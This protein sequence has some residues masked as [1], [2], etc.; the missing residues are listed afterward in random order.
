MRI[1][2][3]NCGR[4]SGLLRCSRCRSVFFCS[5][6]CQRAHWPVHK[7]LCQRNE[8]ADAMEDGD[9]KF[10]SW[11][12]KHG[13]QAVLKDD[14]VD[15]IERAAAA[16]CGSQ[17]REEVIESMYGRLEPKPEGDWADIWL[18]DCEYTAVPECADA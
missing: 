1:I 14:E 7:P 10:A 11:M 4:T 3:G 15:R 12:R 13:K 8:F 5:A 18:F 16:T 17:S 9:K 6:S 2:A